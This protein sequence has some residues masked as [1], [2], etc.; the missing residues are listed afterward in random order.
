MDILSRRDALL[1][2][3]KR[4]FTG[5][6]CGRGH[7]CER[8]VKDCECVECRN[9]AKRGHRERLPPP[10]KKEGT[11]Y[12]RNRGKI[13]AKKQSQRDDKRAS[14]EF[15][16]L[17]E[18]ISKVLATDPQKRLGVSST[19]A[20]RHVISCGD[21]SM[22]GMTRYFTGVPCANG[23]VCEKYVS[24]HNC[25]KCRDARARMKRKFLSDDERKL[26]NRRT[27]TIWRLNGRV[28]SRHRRA[29]RRCRKRSA[30]PS[31]LT[32]DQKNEIL[33]MYKWAAFMTEMSG[34]QHHVDHIYPLKNPSVCGLHVP[35]NLQ[36]IPAKENLMKC[37]S[38]P[39]R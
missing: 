25:V 21:A 12:E 22:L 15:A 34:E 9:Y 27:R 3:L 14:E 23:H 33:G 31:W 20:G 5:V 7:V 17:A 32:R 2:G 38:L 4:Y 6:P 28:K 18:A 37:N 35:W 29:M 8:R 16:C 24:N 1:L 36:V 30:T 10:A 13:L 11:Y 39:S 19:V 26:K